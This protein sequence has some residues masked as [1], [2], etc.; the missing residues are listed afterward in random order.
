MRRSNQTSKKV[1]AC[2]AVG[3]LGPAAAGL[4]AEASS[5]TTHTSKKRQKQKQT[6]SRK[7]GQLSDTY[8]STKHK[9]MRLSADLIHQ[10]EQR[11]NPLG[12]RELILRGYSIPM[13]ENLGVTRDAYDSLDLSD[14]GLTTIGNFPKLPRLSSLLL[15]N[16]RVERIDGLNLQGNLPNLVTLILSNNHIIGLHEVENIATGCQKLEFLCLDGNPVV[17]KFL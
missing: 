14:N 13:I 9:S 15:S 12:E 1:V 16:N 11:T 8:H 17:R 5:I 4:R 10:A 6:E 2:K 3:A 7:K